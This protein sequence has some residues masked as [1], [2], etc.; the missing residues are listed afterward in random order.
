MAFP[1]FLFSLLPSRVLSRATGCLARLPLPPFARSP[2][3][4]AFARL[5]GIDLDEVDG[6]LKSFPSFQA[7]FT[8][9]L[10]EGSRPVDPDPAVL[11]SPVD[12]K[13]L[14]SGPLEEAEKLEV[15]GARFSPE[16]LL[17][18]RDRDLQG[19]SQVTLY[20]SP[21][22]YHRIHAP[23]SGVVPSWRHVPG[24]LLPVNPFTV[25]SVEKVFPGN[26]RIASLWEDPSLGRRLWMVLVG[27][28]NVGSIRVLWDPALRTNRG[29][30]SPGLYHTESPR[31]FSKGEEA[32]RF[33]LGS[34]VVLLLPAGK[35]RLLEETRPGRKVRMGEALARWED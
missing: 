31:R 18:E 32:A 22:D 15:K 13:I 10:K 2:L 30:K 12:G 16:E 1:S 29:K 23:I 14:S 27:A 6:H 26:E 28:L 19:G 5:Y 9:R 21:S 20:L 7:F 8:R 24:R 35:V 3:L 25:H 17:G 33:E 4:G 34:T 11:V